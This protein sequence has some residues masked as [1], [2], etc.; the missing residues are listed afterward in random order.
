MSDDT[1]KVAMV[2]LGCAK[3]LVDSEH[4]LGSLATAGMV[5]TDDTDQA[6]VLVVNTCAF[7]GPAKEESVARLLEGELWKQ[8]VPGRKLVVAGCLAERYAA[9][10]REE[11]PAIDAVIGSEFHDG[12]SVNVTGSFR[13]AIGW[14]PHRRVAREQP[15]PVEAAAAGAVEVKSTDGRRSREDG[16]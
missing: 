7:I 15:R 5:L 9:D 2:H 14:V 16:P 8:Q 6:D 13:G 1:P 11:I 10:L 12:P 4:M 3:N